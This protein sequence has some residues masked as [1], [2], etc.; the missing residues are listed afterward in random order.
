M[1][2]FFIGA[3][4]HVA[5]EP[6]EETKTIVGANVARID[7]NI[8]KNF[9]SQDQKE[10]AKVASTAGVQSVSLPQ[11]QDTQEATVEAKINTTDQKLVDIIKKRLEGEEGEYSV[12]VQSLT[13]DKNVRINDTTLMKAASLY[14]LYLM[15]AVLEEIESGNLKDDTPL[16][17]TVAH[18]NEEL[19][20]AE[21]GYDDYSGTLNYKIST[22]L[23]RVASL[24]DNYSAIMLA[25]KIGWEKVREQASKMGANQTSIQDPISTT[26]ADTALFFQKAYKGEI[27]SPDA[28]KRIIDLL[29]N[30]RLNNRIPAKL[31]KSLRVA[32]KTGELPKLRHDA[33][34]VYAGDNPYIIVLMS[35]NV[36]FEDDAIALLAAISKDVYD[37]LQQTNLKDSQL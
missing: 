17:A 12:V 14:K 15:A 2:S 13:D 20:G 30:A 5:T 24:S 18:L 1:L 31:P 28:S 19:G 37:Y 33:G 29:A 32:H 26:A 34:I 27:V 10:P 22:A 9:V 21:Y 8:K 16:S 11:V 4:I 3:F 6:W 35:Q 23:E 36:K 7:S 25:E